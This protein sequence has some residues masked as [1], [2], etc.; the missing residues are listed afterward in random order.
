MVFSST[1]FLFVFLPVTLILYYIAKQ[2]YQNLILL[3]ASLVFYAI[4]EPRMIWIMLLSVVCNY[5]FALGIEKYGCRKILLA[6]SIFYN[7]GIL[8]VFKYFSFAIRILNLVAKQK[9]PVLEIMLP[10]GISFYTFQS[11]SYVIDVYRG[12][13]HA[14]RNLLHLAL[15]TALFPQLVAGPIVR[16]H[17]IAA[18]IQSRTLSLEGFGAGAKRFLWGFN[19]KVILANHLAVVADHYFTGHPAEHSVLGVWIGSVCF[20]LQIYYDFSAYSDMAIGL[21]SMFGFVFEENF[22]SPYLAASV[23]DF[24]RRWHIS[25]SAWFRDYVYIP[26]GGSRVSV[27]RHIWNLAVV[28]ILTGIWHGAAFSFVAWGFLYFAAL[29][30]EKYI[31]RPEQ[32]S[33]RAFAVVYRAGVLL[34]IHFAWVIFRADGLKAGIRYCLAMFGRYGEGRWY[35][36]QAI[37]M[38]REYGVFLLLAVF[39]CMPFSGRGG[40]IAKRTGFF[41]WAEKYLLPLVCTAAFLWAVS[42]LIL[43]A[44]NPF[45][46]FQF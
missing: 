6:A 19:K 39:F 24:W 3:A 33:S 23:T 21:G 38:L 44:H 22:K 13:V 20:S 42:F 35:D 27:S 10:V 29:V 32:R 1:V 36:A 17:E 40:V 30:M 14:Q 26:L 25:L 31:V 15:Y 12:T 46:Y 9:I 16:Y 2:E 4:G 11:V 18:Q 8:F 5:Y 37:R 43:G 7:L 34:F 45:I 41:V 28:W